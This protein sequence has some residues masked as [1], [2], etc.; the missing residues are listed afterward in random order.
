MS[1][2]QTRQEDE[3]RPGDHGNQN[4]ACRASNSKSFVDANEA[5]MLRMKSQI[6]KT[7]YKTMIETVTAPLLDAFCSENGNIS[8][9]FPPIP[10]ISY[11][12]ELF[13]V[14]VQPRFPVLHIPTFDSHECSPNLL[15]AMAILGSSYS[16]PSQDKFAL[17]YLERARMSIK[18]MQEKDQSCV[19]QGILESSYSL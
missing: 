15:L 5:E 4:L 1:L 6:S 3:T 16:K 17:T 9:S 18:L 12:L 10:T 7:T 8:R 19:S 13:F 14:H 11:F 2:N